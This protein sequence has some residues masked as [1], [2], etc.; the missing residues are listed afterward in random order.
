VTP[1]QTALTYYR[2]VYPSFSFNVLLEFNDRLMTATDFWLLFDTDFLYL[3][4]HQ[5]VTSVTSGLELSVSIGL[6]R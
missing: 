6:Q 5:G 2:T 3:A 1:G 4:A